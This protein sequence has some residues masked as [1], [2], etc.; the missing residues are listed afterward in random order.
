M[1]FA[2]YIETKRHGSPDFPIEIYR[3]KAGDTQYVMEA[4]WHKEFEI[5]RILSGRFKLYLNGE[6]LVL[7]EGDVVFVGCGCLHRGVPD[8]CVYE[9]IVFD[10]AMLKRQQNDAADRFIS[11][12]ISSLA[13]ISSHLLQKDVEIKN[14]VSLLFEKMIKK[15]EYY[16]LEVYGLLFLLFFMLYSFG[17][18]RT[19]M[20]ISH[21]RQAKKVMEIINW[22][23]E[24]FTEPISLDKLSEQTGLSEKYIC[25][26]FKEY[27]SKTPMTYI[28]ELRIEN[29]CYEMTKLKKNV[30]QA[31]YDSGFNDLSYFC[32]TFKRYKGV[33]PNEYRKNI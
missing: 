18:I 25:R 16:Q 17:Y 4:H 9:C 12:V 30:T 26:I 24:N 8:N 10:A 29:A 31:A 28:N 21:G 27:T 2:E 7:A 1:K 20:E 6:E 32:K 11:P 15:D 33:T 14:T 3:V 19:D 5:I 23:N 13:E 22:L